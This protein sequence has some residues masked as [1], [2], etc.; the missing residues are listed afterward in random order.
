MQ[1]PVNAWKEENKAS[2]SATAKNFE[3][4]D[5]TVKRYCAA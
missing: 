3:L 1:Q 2:I 5:S 4:S